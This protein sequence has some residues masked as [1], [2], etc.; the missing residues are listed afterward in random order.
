MIS[1]TETP[2]SAWVVDGGLVYRLS[3]NL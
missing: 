3:A 2:N 1:I